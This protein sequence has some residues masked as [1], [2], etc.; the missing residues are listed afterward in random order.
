MSRGRYWWTDSTPA[1]FQEAF[2]A[3]N[4]KMPVRKVLGPL[5]VMA[6]QS[7]FFLSFFLG[8]GQGPF[9]HDVA[10]TDRFPEKMKL[11]MVVQMEI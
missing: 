1:L 10:S 5:A 8:G 6:D 4:Q 11:E 2:R 3:V 7:S 9:D